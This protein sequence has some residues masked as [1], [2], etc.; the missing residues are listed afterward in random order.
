MIFYLIK[1]IL[2]LNEN[3][4]VKDEMSNMKIKNILLPTS[5]RVFMRTD[6]KINAEIRNHTIRTLNIFKNCN[7]TE[8]SERIRML[9]QEWD[10]ERVLEASAAALMLVSSYLGIKTSKLCFLITGTIGAFMVQHALQGWCPPLPL[11]RK[12]GVRTAEEIHAEK[13][14][15]KIMR[16]DFFDDYST[17]VDVLNMAEK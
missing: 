3:K 13:T 15:L 2:I 17:A 9:N 16:G 6:P 10:I 7:E 4:R 5:Q 12:W 11:V 1:H 14:A 8:I